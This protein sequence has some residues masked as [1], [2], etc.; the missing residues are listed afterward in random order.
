M[1][2]NI[3]LSALILAQ[4]VINSPNYRIQFPNLNSGAGVPSSAGYQVSTTIGQTAA[5][6]Y[7][8]SGYRVKS[9][10]QY[11]HSVIPFSFS[12]SKFS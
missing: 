11:I 6:L 8:S 3:L 7:S 2:E 5:G 10:F 4:A 9:G 1:N 12:V